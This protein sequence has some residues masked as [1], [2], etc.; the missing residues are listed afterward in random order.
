M[1]PLLLIAVLA[2]GADAGGEEAAPAPKLDGKWLIVYAEEGGRRKNAWEQK[3]GTFQGNT[4][5]YSEEGKEHTIKLMFGPHQTVK[6]TML[7]GE[8]GTGD[9][10]GVYIAAQDYFCLSL[11]GG[12]GKAA[13]APGGAGEAKEG[14][15]AEKGKGQS[16]GSFILIL[17][18]QRAGAGGGTR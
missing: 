16:S 10:S 13:K 9:H 4:L 15:A 17:R 11:G 6:A 2:L 1:S 12:S 5:T 7:D 8:A 14:A 18:R 3:Q